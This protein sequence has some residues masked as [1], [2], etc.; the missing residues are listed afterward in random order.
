MISVMPNKTAANDS[1]VLAVLTDKPQRFAA[2]AEKVG[3]TLGGEGKVDRSLQRLKK[4]GKA[5]LV[6]GKGGGWVKVAS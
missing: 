3:A 5:K 2:V 1:A 6:G 4:N